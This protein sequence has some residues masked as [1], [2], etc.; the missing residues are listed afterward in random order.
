MKAQTDVVGCG[1]LPAGGAAA[2]TPAVPKVAAPEAA[3]PRTVRVRT[4]LLDELIDS[5]G[6]ILLARARLRTMAARLD[7]GDLRDLADE[8]TRLAQGLH[9]RVLSARMTPVSILTDR[10]PRVVRDLSLIHI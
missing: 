4:E 5:V 6:E 7:D 8:F 2:G 3:A 1:V 9:D 10:L